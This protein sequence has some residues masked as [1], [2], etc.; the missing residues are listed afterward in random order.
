MSNLTYIKIMKGK[1]LV[2][3]HGEV[4]SPPMG[5]EAR[6]FT[7]FLL[8]KVQLGQPVIM[9]DSRKM[10]VIGPNCHELRIDDH[11]NNCIWRVM[12]KVDSDAIVI[13]DVL[14]KK[15]EDTPKLVIANCQR[16]LALYKQRIKEIK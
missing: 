12:Y 15:T 5:N 8:R 16:R 11:E 1:L 10:P 4:K 3:L 7:G 2:W 14:K 9:P 13:L 6:L